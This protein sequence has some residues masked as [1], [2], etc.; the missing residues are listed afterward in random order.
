M[1][2]NVNASKQRTHHT[3]CTQCKRNTCVKFDAT[4]ATHAMHPTQAEF[5]IFTLSSADAKTVQ[6]VSHW[7]HSMGCKQWQRQDVKTGEGFKSLPFPSH[8]KGR[9]DVGSRFLCLC[10]RSELE[11]G[12]ADG[13][14]TDFD[15]AVLITRNAWQI[16][17]YS[18]LCTVVWPPS[19]LSFTSRVQLCRTSISDRVSICMFARWQHSYFR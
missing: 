3:Q 17:A 18:P 4:Y 12:H 7:M 11:N 13:A 16:L 10:D 5:L 2:R 9:G 19:L 8:P 14:G 1:Q 6:H 15:Y